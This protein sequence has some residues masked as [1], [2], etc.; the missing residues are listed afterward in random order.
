M[1]QHEHGEWRRIDPDVLRAADR[2]NIVLYAVTVDAE[3]ELARSLLLDPLPHLIE[4]V[5]EVEEDW[6]VTIERMNAEISIAQGPH[7]HIIIWIISQLL[8]R[9]HGVSYRVPP[10]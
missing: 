1:G 9:A 8:K 5:A 10:G 6:S 4:H 7:R 3:E 2:D